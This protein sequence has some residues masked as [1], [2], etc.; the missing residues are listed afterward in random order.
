LVYSLRQLPEM[1]NEESASGGWP[2]AAPDSPL[3][4]RAQAAAAI[5][6]VL[7]GLTTNLNWRVRAESF[8]FVL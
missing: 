7:A 1:T 6:F 2:P 3:T 5:N 4:H 8:R